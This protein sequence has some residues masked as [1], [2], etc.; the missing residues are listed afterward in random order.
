LSSPSLARRV[1][2]AAIVLGI[3]AELLFARSAL[4]VNVLVAVIG[5][6]VAVALI[7]R[8]GARMDRLDRWLPPAVV[9]SASFVALR[10][11]PLLVLADAAITAA[12]LGA[13][14]VALAGVA[15]TRGTFLAAV[16]VGARLGFAVPTGAASVILEARGGSGPGRAPAPIT[17]LAPFAR[18]A[19]VAR[20]LVFG[21]PL[22][23]IFVTLFASADAVFGEW[24]DALV[25]I[26]LDLGE[27][28]GRAV[29][30]AAA[31]W[32]AA[33]T[34]WAVR[35]DSPPALAM[36]GSEVRSLGAAAAAVRSGGLRLPATEVV[37]VLAAL[38]LL[39]GVFVGLQ[40]AYLFGGFDTLAATGLT[41]AEY[42][43]RGFFELVVAA[44][45]VGLLVVGLEA[46][47]ERRSRAY[48]ASL[49]GLMVLTAVILASA[50][51]RLRLYQDAY[52]WT[53][54]RF[55]AVAMIAFLGCGLIWAAGLV[56]V[57]RSRWLPHAL[58]A[59]GIAVSIALN[60]IG[61]QG[62]VTVRNLERAM[63]PSL[64]PPGG[65]VALDAAYLSGLGDGAIP[66]IVEA[67][68]RLRTADRLVLLDI[69]AREHER[70]AADP[71]LTGWP[72]WNLDRERARAALED[73]FGR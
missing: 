70:L 37:T 22:F 5:L 28:P 29:F 6:L 27:L 73:L 64:V 16:E 4:G 46:T 14:L 11:D 15:V 24:V 32:L 50:L 39:F 13:M 19:P 52:G 10:A 60:A 7:R 57:A 47:V 36:R 43:R 25:S 20:G 34:L 3:A 33:G 69:L 30:A 26:R 9:V 2:A 68:P 8:P 42:A 38:D 56:L 21:L 66:P 72:G 55:Y 59:S 45:I 40:F 12:L 51:L 61:P 18:L 1:L 65:E 44:T 58:V 54:L 62:F 71:R 48:V 31:A 53:E 63:D 41:Y 35:G 67:L 49:V 23:V 17:R